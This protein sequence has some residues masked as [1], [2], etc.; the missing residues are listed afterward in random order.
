LNN[1]LVYTDTDGEW[2]NFVIGGI[3]GGFSGWQIGEAAGAKGWDMFGYIIG[4]VAIGAAS[5]GASV[6]VSAIGGGAIVAGAA[7]G[8]VAGAGFSGL[9]TNWNGDAMLR[10]GLIGGLSGG[11]CGGVGAAIGG[12]G[13]SFAGGAA[14]NLTGQLLSNDFSFQDINWTSVGVSGAT[15]LGMYQVGGAIN[16]QKY[17]NSGVTFDGKTLSYRQFM[18]MSADFQRSKFWGR[19]F[20]GVLKE[21]G[22]YVHRYKTHPLLNPEGQTRL[23]WDVVNFPADTWATSHSHWAEP[24]TAFGN[25][26]AVRYHSPLDIEFD[27]GTYG[28]SSF[29]VNRYDA[30][31]NSI[32]GPGS[33][34]SIYSNDY[35]MRYPFYLYQYGY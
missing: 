2:I 29:V 23:H 34:M 21:N 14:S 27:N 1:P 19:E 5:S 16:Y 11:V 33:T 25:E 3:I 35:F 20:G 13:G 9:A 22:G 32:V 24:G 30:S 26:I 7:G 28:F 12:V 8:A 4:G 31:F 10:G 17:K 18:G 6:G 15:S